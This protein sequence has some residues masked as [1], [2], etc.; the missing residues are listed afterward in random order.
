ME[1]WYVEREGV[2]LWY[3]EMDHGLMFIADIHSER[4]DRS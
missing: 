3:V 2:G 4:V 1:L